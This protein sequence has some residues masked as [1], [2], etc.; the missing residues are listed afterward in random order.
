MSRNPSSSSNRTCRSALS[1]SASAVAEP[2]LAST[3][4]S[5]EPPFT[6]TRIGT[7]FS[8]AA[9]ATACTWTRPPMLPGLRRKASAP[10]SIAAT[11]HL[12]S[13][14]TSATNGTG[15][16]R[17]TSPRTRAA[18]RSGTVSRTRSA[19][20]SAQRRTCVTK[21]SAS[22]GS[23]VAIVCTE[24][25]APPPRGSEPIFSDRVWARAIILSS[26]QKRDGSS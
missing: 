24:T 15:L 3:S 16:R 4:R 17:R 13:K 7:P 14:C 21:A 25:G 11:A 6:P 12:W 1:T 10:A 20:A 23:A 22:C 9:R 8:F 18:S 19:P 5:R 2:Y 26:S